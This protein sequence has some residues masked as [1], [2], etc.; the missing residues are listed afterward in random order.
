MRARLELHWAEMNHHS[1]RLD[2]A[3]AFR[4]SLKLKFGKCLGACYIGLARPAT[5]K[6]LGQE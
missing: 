3:S 5:G 2:P 6:H 1:A 4:D